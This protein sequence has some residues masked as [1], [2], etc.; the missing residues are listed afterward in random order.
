MKHLLFLLCLAAALCGCAQ[1][2]LSPQGD[3]S[4]VLTGRIETGGDLALPGDAVV[5]V[6]VVDTS[7]VGRPPDVL[8]S[9]TI[10][11]AVSTPIDFRVEYR[12]EDEV[13][14]KGLNIEARIS[15]GGSV[16]FYNQNQY[17]VTPGNA[18]DLHVVTVNPISR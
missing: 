15:Y 9:Q 18:P 3:P 6:R 16:R 13:L 10:R 12:A 7:A 1:I 4:R 11:G 8:G 2:E 14:R 5:V 17:V